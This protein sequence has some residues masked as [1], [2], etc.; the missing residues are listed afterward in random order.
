VF[1]STKSNL[2][3]TRVM[4]IAVAYALLFRLVLPLGLLPAAADPLA[5]PH[6]ICLNAAT[7]DVERSP[8]APIDDHASCDLCCLSSG[9]PTLAAPSLD[10][11]FEVIG[12]QSRAPWFGALP[13]IRGPP[14]AEAWSLP[15][16]QRGPPKIL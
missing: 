9:A 16:A 12:E 2:H 8:V 11:V 4:A 15:R 13:A 3:W 6:A 10:F 5:D 7:G 1:R 14:P